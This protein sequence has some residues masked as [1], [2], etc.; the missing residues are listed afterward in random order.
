MGGIDESTVTF[1][2]T[3]RSLPGLPRKP[4]PPGA[5]TSSLVQFYN[6]SFASVDHADTLS[7]VHDHVHSSTCTDVLR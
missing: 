4:C 1:S 6:T 3:G 2:G 5:Q 7:P